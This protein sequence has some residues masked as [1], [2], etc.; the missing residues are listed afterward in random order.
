MLA[1]VTMKIKTCLDTYLFLA[2]LL[3]IVA[4]SFW[5]RQH[6][7]MLTLLQIVRSH[8]ILI[9]GWCHALSFLC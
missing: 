9:F 7:Q 8:M 2:G 3:Q 1:T 4:I 6:H 5:G